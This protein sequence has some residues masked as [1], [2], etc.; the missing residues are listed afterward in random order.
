MAESVLFL[1]ITPPVLLTLSTL[2][3]AFWKFKKSAAEPVLELGLLIPR[4]V[5]PLVALLAPTSAEPRRSSAV[6]AVLTGVP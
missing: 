1:D 4:Y 6:V 5:P 2:V 3:P